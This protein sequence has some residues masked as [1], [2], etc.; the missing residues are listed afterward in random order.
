VEF[1]KE[2]PRSP[3]GKLLKRQIRD[4]YREAAAGTR[5]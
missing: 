1:R 5:L 3:T 4:A 2:F